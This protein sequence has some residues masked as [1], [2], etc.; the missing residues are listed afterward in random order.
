MYWTREGTVPAEGHG[1]LKGRVAGSPCRGRWALVGRLKKNAGENDPCA[2][3]VLVP[4]NSEG[5][6]SSVGG[7]HA[8]GGKVG[9]HDDANAGVAWHG[10]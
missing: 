2:T 7:N 6:E 9:E 4:Q 5:R 8:V 1:R 10:S 3:R